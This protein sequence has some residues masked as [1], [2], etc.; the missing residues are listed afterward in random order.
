MGLFLISSPLFSDIKD[1]R[2]CNIPFVYHQQPYLAIRTYTHHYQPWV[3]AIDCITLTPKLL[4]KTEVIPTQNA[5]SNLP[6]QTQLRTD[7]T[8]PIRLANHGVIHQPSSA[9]FLTLDL[10]PSAKPLE[11]AALERLMSLAPNPV[12]I[13]IAI[14]GKWLLHH[15]TD[16]QWLQEQVAHHRLDITWINHSFS[17]PYDAQA[18]LDHTFLLTPG[19][20]VDAEILDTETLLLD[21]GLVFS[22]YF[23]FP[24]LIANEACM[25]KLA[26]LHLI[27]LGSDAWLA[28]GEIP[29]PG[30]IILIHG[31]G[32]EPAGIARFLAFLDEHQQDIQTHKLVFGSLS[33]R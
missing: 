33:N 14:S 7:T 22:P 17:H 11:K 24:G 21:R 13:G 27:P 20:S 29:K 4:P 16:L 2:V 12:P 28:K 19:L 30:S 26:D 3:V 6:F 8:P 18:P 25:A 5:F 32:N 15:E 1:Y 31:N 23:R 10:C 9:F